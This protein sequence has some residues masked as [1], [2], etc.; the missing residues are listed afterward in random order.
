MIQYSIKDLENIS[1]IKAHTLRIW[2]LRYKLLKPLRTD[3]NIRYYSNDDMRK[4]LNV[5]LLNTNGVKIS[6]IANLSDTEIGEKIAAIFSNEESFQSQ[7]ESLVIAMIEMDEERF[8]SVFANNILKFGIE[9]TIMNIIYP[10][11]VKIGMLWQTD[12]INPG[13]EHFIFNLIRQKLISAID[14]QIG[15]P[16]E[17]TEKYLLFLPENELHEFSLLFCNYILR[18]EGKKTI[19]LGQSVL[20]G[21][22]K[23]VADIHNP[24][25]IIVIMTTGIKRKKIDEYVANLSS[26]FANKKI[27]IYGYQILDLDFSQYTNIIQYRTLPEIVNSLKK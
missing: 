24:D 3:T 11:L 9:G 27:I 12:S 2:E 8:E 20:I 19:Y 7:V 13:Q 26:T 1:G 22:A 10:F 23:K 14:G 17:N 18:K 6:K 21:D 4:I 16:K 15:K 25:Y 5:S